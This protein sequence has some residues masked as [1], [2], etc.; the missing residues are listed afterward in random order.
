MT[1][2]LLWSH[3]TMALSALRAHWMGPARET[4]I[5]CLRKSEMIVTLHHVNIYC[6][7]T[8]FLVSLG[9]DGHCWV[10]FTQRLEIR[11]VNSNQLPFPEMG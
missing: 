8:E 4:G 2:V 5:L 7:W 10:R 1:C 9:I 3:I 11:S 6:L